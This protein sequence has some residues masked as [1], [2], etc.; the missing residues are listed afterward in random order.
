M[1]CLHLYFFFYI[2]NLISL[3]SVLVLGSFQLDC[4]LYCKDGF[5]LLP[6]KTIMINLYVPMAL[7]FSITETCHN[8]ALEIVSVVKTKFS[9]IDL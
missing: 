8:R 1:M 5:N 2:L 9:F 7:L 6:C 4:Y 3:I